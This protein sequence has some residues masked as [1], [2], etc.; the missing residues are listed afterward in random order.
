MERFGDEHRLLQYMRTRIFDRGYSIVTLFSISWQRLREEVY[1][2]VPTLRRTDKDL[3]DGIRS[4]NQQRTSAHDFHLT[5]SWSK[6]AHSHEI[7]VRLGVPL[8]KPEPE[9]TGPAQGHVAPL[10]RKRE[11]VS[12]PGK[13]PRLSG[14]PS[15]LKQEEVVDFA[16]PPTA[17]CRTPPGRPAMHPH[18]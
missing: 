16:P 3:R 11:E 15:L 2:R 1:R 18:Q 8:G 13:H 7:L 6:E 4:Y 14:H 10:K 12:R 9:A 5:V 17:R